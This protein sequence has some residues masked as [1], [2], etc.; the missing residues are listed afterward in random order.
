MQEAIA[1]YKALRPILK[2]GRFYHLLPQAQLACPD[3]PT[4]GQWEAYALLDQAGRRGAIWVFRAADGEPWRRLPLAGLHEAAE[5][6]LLDVD[7]GVAVT[8]S[9]AQW[10]SEGLPV[11]LSGRT[12]ALILIQPADTAREVAA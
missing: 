5:H 10:L 4:N 11:D 1:H 2:T 9:G 3:L 12:S 6:R 8:A 7:S